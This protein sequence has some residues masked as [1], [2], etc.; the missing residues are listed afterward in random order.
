[1]KTSQF[2]RIAGSLIVLLAALLLTMPS[3]RAAEGTI[4][5]GVTIGEALTVQGVDPLEFG[6]LTVPSTSEAQW[7]LYPQTGST[8]L[9]YAGDV[10]STDPIANDEHQ[11]SFLITGPPNT[12]VYYTI[13][14]WID[15][16]DPNL[17]LLGVGIF[18]DGTNPQLLDASGELVV[19]VGGWLSI[20][21]GVAI[22]AHTDAVITLEANY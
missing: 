3:T 11:G 16:A 7:M 13:S 5:A 9:H 19:H 10:T 15:F 6:L 22:G 17:S 8:L 12:S 1:M 4:P 20:N 2:N 14:D 18:P 21:P